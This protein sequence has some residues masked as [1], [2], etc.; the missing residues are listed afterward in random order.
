MS[1]TLQNERRAPRQARTPWRRSW[2]AAVAALLSGCAHQSAQ[3]PLEDDPGAIG[4]DVRVAACRDALAAPAGGSAAVLDPADIRILAWNVQKR[5][6]S[7]WRSDFERLATD[8]DFVL[9]QEA[10]L[11]HRGIAAGHHSTFAAGYRTARR[12]TGV[13]T[14]SRHA[15][16]ASCSFTTREPW[17]GTP[18]STGITLH[19]LAGVD[20]ALAVVNVHAVNFS[21]GLHDYRSQ[22]AR[23]LEVLHDHRGPII[24][25]GDFNTWR[26]RRLAVVSELAR[27]LGLEPVSFLEDERVRV[28]GFALDHIYVRDLV[29]QQSGTARVATSDHNPMTAVLALPFA[30]P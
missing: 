7:A 26:G 27:E 20:G 10:S 5:D 14:L 3:L 21:L 1:S 11:D 6:G 9:M 28:F 16:L 23:I 24:L 8:A 2:L 12:V 17:L 29:L 25:A 4:M 15:P 19:A 13:M 18:K 22:F 30:A